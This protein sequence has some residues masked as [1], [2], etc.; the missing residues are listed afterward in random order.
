MIT[1]APLA[2]HDT[3]GNLERRRFEKGVRKI[4]SCTLLNSDGTAHT[5]KAGAFACQQ[6]TM[7]PEYSCDLLINKRD[8]I[9]QYMVVVS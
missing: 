3:L 8:T 6:R 5:Y 9:R 7:Q 4:T 2:G 1:M